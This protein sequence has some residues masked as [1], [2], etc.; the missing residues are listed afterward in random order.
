[1]SLDRW[2]RIDG[3]SLGFGGSG[4]FDDFSAYAVL[5]EAPT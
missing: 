2:A 5:A 1:M 4:T 3:P